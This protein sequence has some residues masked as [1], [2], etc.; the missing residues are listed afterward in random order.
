LGKFAGLP[1]VR[2]GITTLFA[3]GRKRGC[4]PEADSRKYKEGSDMKNGIGFFGLVA[5]VAIIGIGAGNA[6]AIEAPQFGLSIGGG[7]DFDGGGIGGMQSDQ[8]SNFRHGVENYGFGAWLFADA[9]FAELSV[10]FRVGPAVQWSEGT[11]TAGGGMFGGGVMT[12]ATGERKSGSFTAMDISLVG[13]F[14]FSLRGGSIS[15]FP[16]LGA[17]YNIVLSTSIDDKSFSDITGGKSVSELSTFRIHFGVGSDFDIS[18]T[19]F[20][21]AALL[22]NYRF[23]PSYFSNFDGHTG[24]GD[25]GGT[26]QLGVGIRL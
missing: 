5:A 7:L 21:R 8:D 14:P 2:A 4:R 9:T 11:A 24:F 25:I 26:V 15:L 23:A 16:L 13:K 22:G 10:A 19:L 18:E 17:G 6:F 3:K 12:F 1:P 20:F